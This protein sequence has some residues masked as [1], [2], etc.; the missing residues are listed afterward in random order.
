V[1]IASDRSV[2]YQLDGDPGGQ[3]PLEIEVLPSRL[4]ILAS[5]RRLTA[6]G[7]ERIKQSTAGAT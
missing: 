1:R 4:T 5:A 6:L 7:L 3:L 2:P